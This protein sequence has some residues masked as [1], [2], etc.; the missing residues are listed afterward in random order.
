MNTEKLRQDNIKW[1][2]GRY[3]PKHPIGKTIH[4]L[5]ASE[6]YTDLLEYF[7]PESD[8]ARVVRDLAESQTQPAK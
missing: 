4:K 8:T 7:E 2:K 1:L 3:D 6:K 5:I